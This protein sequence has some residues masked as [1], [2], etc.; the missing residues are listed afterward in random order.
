MAATGCTIVA[1]WMLIC[2]LFNPLE[3]LS[4]SRYT[5]SAREVQVD[6]G[7]IQEAVILEYNEDIWPALRDL[8]AGQRHYSCGRGVC[9]LSYDNSDYDLHD[10]QGYTTQKATTH[11]PPIGETSKTPRNQAHIGEALSDV[12]IVLIFFGSVSTVFFSMCMCICMDCKRRVARRWQRWRHGTIID[13]E[14]GDESMMDRMKMVWR[15]RYNPKTETVSFEKT[16]SQLPPPNLIDLTFLQTDAPSFGTP[17]DTPSFGTPLAPVSVPRRHLAPIDTS[18]PESAAPSFSRLLP[19]TISYIP[20]S[21]IDTPVSLNTPSSQHAEGFKT[22]D[23]IQHGE[24]SDTWSA[25]EGSE[26]RE[27]EI[28]N[29]YI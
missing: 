20:N 26:D 19:M 23:T 29:V 15:A 5:L 28:R 4:T 17:K 6:E 9:T 8:W 3:V 1:V 27:V 2:R 22:A 7:V 21:Q 16:N 24:D 10:H 14:E 11:K 18:T 25:M 13:I 12:A